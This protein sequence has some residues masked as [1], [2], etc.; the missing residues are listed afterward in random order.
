MSPDQ[1][2]PGCQNGASPSNP[3]GSTLRLGLCCAFV[4]EPIRFRRTTARYVTGLKPGD[5]H[6]L[7]R[8]IA[9]HNARALAQ[10]VDWCAAHGV[11][12]F[13]VNSEI[14]PLSTHPQ[15]GYR[16][17]ELDQRGELR[18]AFVEAGCRARRG[19]VRLSFHP[20]QFVVLGSS[21]EEVVRSSL[22]ELEHQASVAQLIGAEQLTLHGGGAQ[23]GKPAALER[24]CRNVTRLSPRARERIALENDDRLYT[25]RDLL[26]LCREEGIPLV[27]DVHHH[28][29]NPDGLSVEE[30]TELAMSTWSGREPWAHLSTPRDGWHRDDPRRHADYIQ[31]S[32]MPTCWVGK[33]MTLDIEAKAKELAVLRLAQWLRDGS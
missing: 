33:R 25:V 10:A 14:L 29:C 18:A 28:R 24:L 5:R 32:D 22:A 27:Y 9:A 6:E 11:G 8:Q 21:R 19:H 3:G 26:P 20:D 7:L 12:A 1:T 31:P 15:V 2:L 30:A 13:R 17:E 23:G 4:E 16:L